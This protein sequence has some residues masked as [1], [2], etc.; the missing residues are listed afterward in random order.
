MPRKVLWVYGGLH[1][2]E[3]GLKLQNY[4]TDMVKTDSSQVQGYL[5]LLEH[6]PV[7]TT[8]IRS[9]NYT[10][11][12]EQNLTKLG[13]QFHRTDRGGLI[14][15]HGIGQLTAYPILDLRHFVP[16]VRWYVRE[17]ENTIIDVCK[18]FNLTGYTTENPGVWV[19]DKKVCAIG[20]HVNQHITSHGIA[21]NCNV[22]LTWFDQ[23]VPCGLVGKKAT[24]LTA[25][26]GRKV[27]VEEAQEYFLQRFSEHF[28]CALE[29]TSKYLNYD[30]TKLIRE[31]YYPQ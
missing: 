20:I 28:G 22:N 6:L 7:Y 15:F 10:K 2:Y 9:K 8:G 16:K 1:T 27:T 21:L 11:E 23:I 29:P 26:T 4:L 30:L 19:D 3:V 5:L 14:T 31:H 18:D 12:Y 24:S 17:L 25:L 13:A